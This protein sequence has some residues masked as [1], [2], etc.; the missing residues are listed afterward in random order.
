MERPEN[1]PTGILAHGSHVIVRLGPEHEGRTRAGIMDERY[2]Y[3]ILT[4]PLS[5]PAT[6][7]CYSSVA[8]FSNRLSQIS[9]YLVGVTTFA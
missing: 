4:A 3:G 5:H 8:D 9:D 7:A 2:A 6:R 1:L